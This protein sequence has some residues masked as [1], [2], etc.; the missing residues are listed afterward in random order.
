MNVSTYV[1]T[2]DA[3]KQTKQRKIIKKKG[4]NTRPLMTDAL[5][6]NG[7]WR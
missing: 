4:A 6:F 2:L 5:K 7:T 1:M 3:F